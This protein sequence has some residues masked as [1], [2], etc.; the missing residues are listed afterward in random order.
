V[1]IMENLYFGLE[2]LVIGFTVV[3]VTLYVLY[4]VLVGFSRACA[5]PAKPAP[6]T[7]HSA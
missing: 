1:D 3:M 7:E 2:V 4:L 5:R 6:K